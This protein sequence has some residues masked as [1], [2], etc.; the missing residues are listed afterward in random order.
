[1]ASAECCK[2]GVSM[3]TCICFIKTGTCAAT[4]DDMHITVDRQTRKRAR[5]SPRCLRGGAGGLPQAMQAMRLRPPWGVWKG[6]TVF[7]SDE[8]AKDLNCHERWQQRMHLHD[9]HWVE[10]LELL[11]AG[12]MA[13]HNSP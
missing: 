3:G 12:Q 2:R 1:M 11:G 6:Y 9:I 10:H 5:R 7:G 4:T 13:I 8:H